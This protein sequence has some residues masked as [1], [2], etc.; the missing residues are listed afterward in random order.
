MKKNKFIGTGVALVTPFNEDGSVDYVSLRNLINFDLENG[1]DF[2]VALGTTSESP[3]LDDD[4]KRKVVNTVVNTVAGR[5]PVL[6]G[7]GGNNTAALLKNIE[8]QDFTGIDGILSVVPYYNKP[9]QSGMIA[10]FTAIADASPVPVVLYN[11]PGRTGV[12]MQA[13][14]TVRLACHDNIVAVKEASGNLQQI[15]EILRDKPEDFDLLSGDD[16]I[17]YPM[18]ALGAK[19]VISVAANAYPEMF[20]KM[21][22]LMLE[23]RYD[24]ALPLHY[25][26]LKMNGL[27][28]ADG[29]P[30]GI[31]ALLAHRG[32]CNNVLRLPLLP[33]NDNVGN[34]IEN[35]CK[36]LL[37]K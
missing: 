30:A 10:H 12:N 34:E 1:S 22:H 13:A 26:M 7:M 24:E 33:V 29:N 4:E 31:K 8:R 9:N 3:T 15:M 19:G 25:A 21:V 32:L 35:N 28:F 14:T 16:G 27:I 36:Y 2:M 17:T 18:M 20:C 23:K 5:C 6:L 37:V 11:V